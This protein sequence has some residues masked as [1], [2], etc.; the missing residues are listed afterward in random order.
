MAGVLFTR[1]RKV[2]SEAR[3]VSGDQ[4]KWTSS[5]RYRGK[6]LPTLLLWGGVPAWPDGYQGNLGTH[7]TLGQ[8]G[9]RPVF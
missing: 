8:H 9:R 2:H 7:R 4:A 6:P 3:E 1:G 5:S